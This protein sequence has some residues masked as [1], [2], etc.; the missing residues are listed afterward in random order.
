MSNKDKYEKVFFDNFLLF[1]AR[2]IDDPIKP[3]PIINTFLNIF[4]YLF[5]AF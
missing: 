4:K 2:S 3:H 5:Y 1:I